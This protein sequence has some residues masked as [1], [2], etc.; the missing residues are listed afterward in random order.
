MNRIVRV[1]DLLRLEASQFRQLIIP[2]NLEDQSAIDEYLRLAPFVVVRRAFFKG[3]LIPVGIRGYERFQ[4]IAAWCDPKDIAEVVS[5]ESLRTSSSGRSLPVFHALHKLEQRWSQLRYTWGPTGSVGF[6]L[7][8]SVASATE[9]SDLDLVLRID[10]PCP[11]EQLE[12]IA[13]EIAD[14]PC[15]IDLQVE[16]PFGAF[17]LSEYFKRPEKL[18]LRTLAGPILVQD[19]WTPSV[20]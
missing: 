12:K 19:P 7:A 4:R 18:L 9:T 15:A 3:K 17:A 20:L 6:E 5:P 10:A 13:E 16:T 1:H 11:I 8:T 14:M 2:A